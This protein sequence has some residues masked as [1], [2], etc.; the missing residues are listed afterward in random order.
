[1]ASSQK[2]T[3]YKRRHLENIRRNEEMMAAL[4]IHSKATQLF[5][6]SSKRQSSIKGVC[7]SG[8]GLE[9]GS[10]SW[11]PEYIRQ[12]MPVKNRGITN[13]RFLPCSN[14]TTTLG[15]LGF[16][17]YL[18]RPHL[19]AISGISMRQHSFLKMMSFAYILAR[20]GKCSTQ[21]N[22]HEMMIN[23]IDFNSENYNI[24]ATSSSNG[25][26]CIWDLR[27]INVDQPKPLK[28]VS[29]NRV[30]QSAYFSPSS[31]LAMT[32]GFCSAVF[33][34]PAATKSRFHI[35]LD[36]LNY[37]LLK[38]DETI[39]HSHFF[40]VICDIQQM[41]LITGKEHSKFK[42]PLLSLDSMKY[43]QDVTLIPNN[44]SL[45]WVVYLFLRANH[46]MNEWLA[47]VE[48]CQTILQ[49]T[50][51]CFDL[52]ASQVFVQLKIPDLVTVQSILQN[53][54]LPGLSTTGCFDFF[55]CLVEIALA[56]CCQ[57]TLL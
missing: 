32:R 30:V 53:P 38:L 54:S 13:L 28:E 40:A 51:G 2:L 34:P 41:L 46:E 25:T 3:E 10:L 45:S 12:F 49:S 9:L 15:M 6:T 36:C 27:S 57:P 43:T 4:R 26:A 42:R 56:F 24:M 55:I 8:S 20:V 22:L 7:E 17:I 18:Y 39:K 44:L 23:S 16:G 35:P 19:Y 48:E 50:T 5:S 52:I 31:S 21:W 29:H 33:K 1:M 47:V 37:A 11:K 14:V